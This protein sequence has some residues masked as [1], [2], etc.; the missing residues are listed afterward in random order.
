MSVEINL[1]LLENWVAIFATV[2]KREESRKVV[3]VPIL[4]IP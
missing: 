2:E 1:K 4:V 3:R